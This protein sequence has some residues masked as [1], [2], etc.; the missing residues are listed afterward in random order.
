MTDNT[1]PE[2]LREGRWYMVNK[3]GMATLCADE[4][5]AEREAA[6]AQAIWPGMGPHRAVQLVDAGRASLQSSG[7]AAEDMATASAQGFRDGVAFLSANAG[8]PTPPVAP[9][10]VGE[11]ALIEKA[12]ESVGITSLLNH[13]AASCVFT[14]GCCGVSQ[15]HI[16]AY[17]RK[18]ALHCAVALAAPPTAQ[19]GGWIGVDEAPKNGRTLLLGYFNNAG[20][21][22]TTRGQWISQDYIDE[23]ADDPDCMSPGWHETTVEDDD[24]KCWPIDPTHWMPLPP[25]PTSA[26][27]VEHG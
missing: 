6:D 21:W 18:I 13:G 11:I 3:D 17:T 23:Y 16:L 20:K 8:E 25:A 24:G 1:Q 2:A 10:M 22:R 27:G 12:L 15:D 26:D 19:A 4:A 14:E 5:D 9:P 7:F